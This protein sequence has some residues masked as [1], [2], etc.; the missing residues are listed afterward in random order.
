MNSRF[1]LAAE[2]DVPQLLELMRELYQ[3]EGMLFDEEVARSGLNKTLHDPT[4][5]SAYLILLDDQL[6]GYF[7]LTSCFSLEFYGKCGLL[8]ELYVREAFRGRKLG[9][10]TIEFAEGICRKM[11]IKALRLEVEEG[12]K[13]A[14][15]LYNSL[16]FHRDLRYLFTKRL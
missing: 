8:D 12:N 2:K 14:Q 1:Q 4:V 16:G 7:V 11:G 10:A 5:G 15:S 3:H 9:K 6:A 13:V